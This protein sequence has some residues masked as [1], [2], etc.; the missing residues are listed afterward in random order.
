[1]KFKKDGKVFDNIQDLRK[2]FCYRGEGCSTCKVVKEKSETMW[3]ETFFNNHMVKAAKIIG[4]EVIFEKIDSDNIEK[5]REICKMLTELYSKKNHDY[6]NSF[7]ELYNK[8][9]LVSVV[10]RLSDKLNRLKQLSSGKEQ[11]VNDE[12]I[13]DTLIDLANY[14][15]MAIIELDNSVDN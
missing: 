10:I 7:T 11:K 13:R 15:I 12:S 2:Y 14:S 3:C 4:A 8:F 1:M 9:G 6:G 5:H